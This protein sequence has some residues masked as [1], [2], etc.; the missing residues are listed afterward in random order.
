MSAGKWNLASVK[1]TCRIHVRVSSHNV[2]SLERSW[3]RRRLWQTWLF[4]SEG[5]KKETEAYAKL[6]V[7]LGAC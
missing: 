6:F 1:P 3:L 2:L 5:Q 7:T 4:K